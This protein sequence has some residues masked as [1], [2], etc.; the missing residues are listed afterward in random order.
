LVEAN[1]STATLRISLS[2][3]G[4]Q[5]HCIV[6][7]RKYSQ[8]RN[9]TN[10]PQIRTKFW[11]PLHVSRLYKHS[12]VPALCRIWLARKFNPVPEMFRQAKSVIWML[13]Q[14]L[15][16]C[17]VGDK[18]RWVWD[19]SGMVLTR[20]NQSTRT[21]TC[22]GAILSTTNPTHTA[23]GSNPSLCSVRS[24]ASRLFLCYTC[25]TLV[26]K[27]FCFRTLY[28]QVLTCKDTHIPLLQESNTY[29]HQ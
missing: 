20:K 1:S 7:H 13:S 28:T 3:L 26:E 24:E 8:L 25:S 4:N 29:N 21:E 16:L 11:T 15:R 19:I 23:L 5:T 17:K 27:S 10:S 9:A 12:P 22:P 2:Y 14:Q 18:W 6:S